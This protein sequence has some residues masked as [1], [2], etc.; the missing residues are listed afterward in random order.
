MQASR[1]TV[2]DDALGAEPIMRAVFSRA[3]NASRALRALADL[4]AGSDR[5][6]DVCRHLRPGS[7]TE[8]DHA[9]V[10]NLTEAVQA[11]GARQS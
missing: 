6:H 1:S 11:A 8:A 10:R 2:D 5:R 7:D 4:Q 3:S 9:G